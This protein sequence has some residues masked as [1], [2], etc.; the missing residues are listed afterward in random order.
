MG[1]ER[2]LLT[3]LIS[4]IVLLQVSCVWC[5]VIPFREDTE[6]PKFAAVSIL[7]EIEEEE[8]LENS[9]T[10]DQDGAHVLPR[11]RVGDSFKF[12]TSRSPEGSEAVHFPDGV[13]AEPL[14]A[15]EIPVAVSAVDVAS[16][17][18]PTAT[19]TQQAGEA[20]ESLQAAET[21]RDGAKASSADA[22][23]PAPAATHGSGGS[24]R[25]GGGSSS[26][27][28]G[29]G[30]PFSGLIPQG[31]PSLPGLSLGGGGN[32]GGA[33][34]VQQNVPTLFLGSFQLM[35]MPM[36]SASDVVSMMQAG[37]SLFQGAPNLFQGAPNLFQGLPSLPGL[38][39]G[40]SA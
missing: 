40:S 29:S 34:A 38:P 1:S 23:A 39:G 2:S 15:S 31:L 20:E 4:G 7:P 6:M 8:F 32:A 19:A 36:P 33:G 27:G 17:S 12:R 16:A 28:G 26:G 22:A 11:S 25:A 3:V 13:E 24:L 18:E 14:E 30:L 10:L 35:R 21:H 5:N 37:A 9:R